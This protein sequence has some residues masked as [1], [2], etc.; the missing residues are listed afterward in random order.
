MNYTECQKLLDE[1]QLARYGRRKL[2][3]NTYLEPRDG[4][5]F[6]VKLHSTDVLTFRCDGSVVLNSGGWRT[7]T[8]KAR[9]NDYLPSGWYVWQERGQWFLRHGGWQG[10]KDW[11][12]AD[13]IT[14]HSDGTVTG[15]GEAVDSA[16]PR[17]IAAYAKAYV[18]AFTAGKIPKPSGGDCWMCL[19]RD[20]ETGKPWGGA[21]HI[22]SH[23]EEKY[24]VPSLLMNAVDR[25]PV[26]RMAMWAIQSIWDG[27]D[28]DKWSADILTYQ[29]TSSIRRW[30]KSQ[31]GLAA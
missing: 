7:V 2:A 11:P 29:L 9:M 3:N 17:K 15:E 19:L 8:T 20:A 4:D 28:I 30:C 22:L 26:S 24:Y 1:K 6:A 12:F 10:G 27:K 5:A 31:V 21:D 16:L 13:G 25:Y 23:L 14:I 18:K